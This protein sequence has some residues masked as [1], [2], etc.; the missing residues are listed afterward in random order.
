MP[1]SLRLFRPIGKGA[2]VYMAA[3]SQSKADS[4]IREIKASY[5]DEDPHVGQIIFL[6]LDLSDLAL[7]REAALHFRSLESHLDVLWNNAGVFD[8]PA[9][10]HSAQGFEL[11]MAVNCLGPY[12]LSKLLLPQL[13]AAAI[14][15]TPDSV[16]IVWASSYVVDFR[17]RTPQYGIPPKLLATPSKSSHETY[18]ISKCG[19]WFLA[20]EFSRRGESNGIVS[21]A[22]N[23]GNIKT[24]IFRDS[25]LAG[26]LLSPLLHDAKLGAYSELWAGLSLD[27]KRENGGGYVIPWGRWHPSPRKDLL[28]AIKPAADGGLGNA[29]HFWE[30]C[31]GNTKSFASA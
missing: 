18:C 11:Q 6:Q 14:K 3:R 7:V 25:R 4:A 22:V 12:L 30:W 31:N 15:A 28:H 26:L 2:K 8:P 24:N 5:D 20:A 13:H 27:V 10:S 23:P 9:G 21:I 19:N 16:R 17:P 29:Q 1:H